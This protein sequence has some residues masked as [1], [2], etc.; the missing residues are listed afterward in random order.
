MAFNNIQDTLI[1]AMTTIAEGVASKNQGDTSVYV[2]VTDKNNQTNTYTAYYN[3]IMYDNVQ[4]VSGS[5]N[6]GDKALMTIMANNKKVLYGNTDV[7]QYSSGTGIDI[8]NKNVSVKIDNDTIKVDS[9]GNLYAEGGGSGGESYHAGQ[10]ISISEHNINVN[11]DNNT[12]VVGSDNKL[13]A[14]NSGA[15]YIAGNGIDINNNTISV[16]VKDNSGLNISNDKL[17]IDASKLVDNVTI[18]VNNNGDI[19]SKIN[20]DPKIKGGLLK[21]ENGLYV[22]VDNSSIKIDAVTGQIY[23]VGSSSLTKTGSPTQGIYIDTNGVP[24]VMS[25]ALNKTVPSNAVFTDT[26]YTAG[27]GLTLTNTVFSADTEILATKSDIEN[28]QDKLSAV[29]SD[30]KGIYINADGVPTIM[31]YSIAANVPSDAKFTDTKYSAGNGLTLTNTTFAADISILATKTELSNKQDILIQGDNITINDNVISATDT[32]YSAG[33]GLSLAGNSFSVDTNTI[34][35]KV[36]VDAKQDKLTQTG[37]SKKGIYINSNGVPTVMTYSVEANVPQNAVFTDTTYSAGNGLNLSGTTFNIDYSDEV[38]EYNRVYT[39]G[40]NIIGKF[41]TTNIYGNAPTQHFN[42]NST[43]SYVYIEPTGDDVNGNGTSA[44]PFRTLQTAFDKTLNNGWTDCR[45]VFKNFTED[46]EM[47]LTRKNIHEATIHLMN[48]SNALITIKF[49]SSGASG[50]PA[51]YNVH[52]NFDGKFN[53]GTGGFKVEC[54]TK[55]DYTYVEGGTFV[56]KDIHFANK[57]VSF[58][59]V[60]GIYENCIFDGGVDISAGCVRLVNCIYNQPELI[61]GEQAKY[62]VYIRDGANVNIIGSTVCNSSR[63]TTASNTSCAFFVTEAQAIFDDAC[64]FIFNKAVSTAVNFQYCLG[65]RNGQVHIPQAV[66]TLLKNNLGTNIYKRSAATSLINTG[67]SELPASGGGGTV[68]SAGEGLD[69][70]NNIFSVDY[71]KTQKILSAADGLNLS[72]DTI[73]LASK[74]YTTSTFP[75]RDTQNEK[76]VPSFNK[77]YQEGTYALSLYGAGDYSSV[78]NTVGFPLTSNSIIYGELIVSRAYSTSRYVQI[79]IYAAS[80]TASYRT[81]I[82]FRNSYNNTGSWKAWKE[83]ASLDD[84]DNININNLSLDANATDF[85]WWT[86][87]VNDVS[88]DMKSL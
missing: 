23:S 53:G 73:S 86:E 60:K 12:I 1:S 3:G 80:S 17:D 6:I 37:T 25:Y 64:I 78:A 87:P 46:T 84:I 2:L 43:A 48:Q 58:G 63:T 45:V 40:K 52:F 67:L 13:K 66:L 32:V 54:A 27:N 29:G 5:L 75:W 69:L 81:R 50:K 41:G 21:D 56:Y 79:Y 47:I 39:T 51:F 30:T 61:N 77:A 70:N 24:Q 62:M 36:S 16:K 8:N 28:K 71:T 49:S 38:K 18:G 31:R 15:S 10:G 59:A 33:S 9:Q 82:F 55:A 42:S 68:Y 11:V 74:S 72:N 14:I 85:P 35:T 44:N 34:A 26:K 88:D 83:V 4:C 65:L 22:N 7:E 20:C 19:F 57:V 76:D